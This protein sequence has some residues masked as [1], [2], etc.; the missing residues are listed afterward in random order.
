MD[1]EKAFDSLEWNF[2]FCILEKFNF[3][4]KFIK[5]I[6][7]IIINNGTS[8]GYFSI[9]RG[10][11]QGDPMSPYLFILS[12]EALAQMVRHESQIKG[13]ELPIGV[14]SLLLYADDVTG[15]VADVES[16]KLFFTFVKIF[17]QY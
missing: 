10:V 11:R 15:L 8:S 13:L 17:G 7:L 16:A 3:D 1:F 12:L 14:V 6:R 4:K 9:T 5:W 2:I